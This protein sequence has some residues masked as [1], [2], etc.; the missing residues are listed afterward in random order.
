MVTT[1]V[2][3]SPVKRVG[4]PKAVG[5]DGRAW[6]FQGLLETWSKKYDVPCIAIMESKAGRLLGKTPAFTVR[7][8]N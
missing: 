1:L 5:T 6:I 3:P 2:V 8:A 4:K 7:P